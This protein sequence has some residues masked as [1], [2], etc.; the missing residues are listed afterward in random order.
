MLLT[1]ESGLE[2]EELAA[3]CETMESYLLRRSVC[4]MTNKNYNR[5][6][7]QLARKF[8]IE[9]PSGAATSAYLKELKGESAE[10]PTDGA[11][12]NAWNTRE[13]Y[14]TLSASRMAF[15]LTRLNDDF[16]SGKTETIK[17]EDALSIEHIMPQGWIANWPLPNGARGIDDLRLWDALETDQNTRLTKDRNQLVQTIGNLT[18]VRQALNASL[19]NSA[20]LEKKR[21]LMEYSLLPI[22]LP[23]QGV[24]M[25]DDQM[26]I[27]RSQLLFDRA[28]KLW[29]R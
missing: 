11:F 28:L 9:K 7:M 19:S 1:L 3:I 14:T 26:I 2:A 24:V 5:V 21:M 23:L 13:I 15:I 16:A 4:G 17:V 8:K 6:V 27:T 10:W 18:L 29:P 22:N 20:W 12:Q 25:W